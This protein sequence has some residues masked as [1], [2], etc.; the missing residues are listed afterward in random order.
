[1]SHSRARAT[2]AGLLAAC[3]VLALGVAPARASFGLNDFD[4]SFEEEDH[5]TATQAGSHPYEMTTS[6]GINYTGEG[7]DAQPDG[8]I[9][10]ATFSQIAGLVGDPAA[11][12][13]CATADF[14]AF[15]AGK[16]GN[17]CPDAAAVGVAHVLAN[18]PEGEFDAA[19]YNLQ[20]PPGVVM[21][22]GFGVERVPV[23]V[24]IRLNTVPEYNVLASLR[25]T[26][27]V[28]KVF[29]ATLTLWGVPGDSS[30]DSERGHCAEE[31]GEC[32]AAGPAKPLLTLPGSCADSQRTSYEALSWQGQA[33]SG[34]EAMPQSF[35]GCGKLPFQPE[36]SAAPSTDRAESSSGLSFGIDFDQQGLISRGGTA[37]STIKEAVVSL[38][39]GVTANPSLAEGLG[40]CS[41][42]DLAREGLGTQP[43]QGCPE[44]SKLGTVEVQTPLLEEPVDGSVYLA[45]PENPDT[46]AH[47]NPFG[48][49]IA[50]YIV[51]R[52]ESLGILVKLPAKVTPD[53]ATGALTTTVSAIPQ[54]P[55]SHFSFHFREGQRAPL[56]T[57]PACG[58]YTAEARFTPWARP[59]EEVP[60]TAS[61]HISGGPGGSPCPDAS[62]PPFS[63]GFEAGSENNAAGHYSPFVMRLTRADG[64][65]DLTRFSATLPRGVSGRLAGLGRCPDTQIALARTKSAGAELASPSCPAGSRIG[66]TL[67]AAGVGGELTYVPGSLY[68]AGSYNGDPLSVVAVTPAK[69]GP[70]DVGTVVVRE[71]LDIDPR[72]A[73]VHVD[74]SASDP[75]PHILAGIPLKLRELRVLADRPNFT[76]NPTSCDPRAT[77][78]TAWGAF[79]GP[80]GV[81]SPEASTSLSDRYQAAACLNLPF[82]PRLALRLRGGT[83][84]GANP[85]LQAV[86]RAHPE[87]ANIG[88]AA[89]TLP[90]SAFLDQS[91]IRTVCTRVQFAAGPGHG[92]HCPSGARYG[93]AV[94]WT[95]LLDEPLRGPVYLRS[96]SHKL[97]DLVAA[98]HGIVDVEVPG[99]IDSRHGGIRTRFQG[100]P[101]VPVSRFVLLMQGGKKGLI[102]NSRNLCA[103]RSRARAR[104]DGQNGRGQDLSPVVRPLSCPKHRR[105]KRAHRRHRRANA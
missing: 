29:G 40:A 16:E 32:E 75:I 14:L 65:R 17:E 88:S 57:P 97:P 95:P 18:K 74:G 13:R 90:S 105:A 2:L 92:A 20:P 38:P 61:F 11:T 10:D 37:A 55:F 44:S 1:M 86:L 42:A 50:F 34:Q 33:D 93:Y 21:R 35:T 28:L 101:D 78:A 6:F 4:V 41:E 47:E 25:N 80:A 5:T 82:G 83:R 79:L 52:S 23:V 100:L 62:S 39:A 30:H 98:L 77:E 15:R 22:L 96:S 53:P 104:F 51:L 9:K 76:L 27:Q 102:V 31:G 71:A 81:P 69:A 84:R 67:A 70:F 19:V 59:E 45:T 46:A 26:R 58:A 43:G 48:S 49:L 54:L 7:E 36:I 63:P 3:C 99:R 64:E 94:A 91:H 72:T 66:S 60:A 56:I 73:I 87:D 85:A 24:D 89:V 8:E 68:L 12:E 103:R